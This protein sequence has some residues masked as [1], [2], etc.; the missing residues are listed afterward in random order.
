[1]LKLGSSSIY[2]DLLP[3]NFDLSQSSSCTGTRVK[4]VQ[5]RLPLTVTSNPSCKSWISAFE[6]SSQSTIR[7]LS[8]PG[9][10]QTAG[11]IEGPNRLLE[12][13]RRRILE[14]I[15][16][17]GLPLPKSPSAQLIEDAMGRSSLDSTEMEREERGWWSLQFQQL[18]RENW[19]GKTS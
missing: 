1:M 14:S 19:Y 13:D 11:D 5:F 18:L 16:E 2:V 4:T 15:L 17:T 3:V 6:L 7:N 10:T 8:T 9:L 12:Q